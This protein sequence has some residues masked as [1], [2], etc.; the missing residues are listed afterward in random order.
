MRSRKNI[1]LSVRG[2]SKSYTIAH[3]QEK[4]STLAETL[5]QRARHPFRRA[6]RETFWALKDVS[7]EINKGEVVGIIGRNGAGKSTLL[8]ILSRI[9][10]PTG[11][12]IDLYGRVG[13]LLEVGT[14]FH[15]ELT[16]RENIFLNGAVLGMTR[17][18]IRRQFDTIVAFAEIERFLDTPVKRYSSGMYVRLAFSIAAHLQPDILIL[19]EVLAV[20]DHVFQEKCFN[21]MQEV[22]RNG[23][24]LLFVS[25]NLASVARLCTKGIYLAAGSIE[26]A[27]P[28]QEVLDAYLANNVVVDGMANFSEPENLAE[29]V[30]YLSK[31]ELVNDKSKVTGDVDVRY[32]YK[33]VLHYQVIK[34]VKDVEISLKI[35]DSEMRAVITSSLSEDNS[36]LL[37]E[38]APGSYTCE[39]EFPALFIVPGTYSVDVAIHQPGQCILDYRSNLMQ[40]NIA[41]TGTPYTRYGDYRSIGAVIHRLAW[42]HQRIG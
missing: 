38:I 26:A 41:D 9:T 17:N 4:Q 40:F 37:T 13:S 5:L 1:A 25:H 10:E 21:K 22:A 15:P 3:E 11:G 35:R 19:D 12:K 32:K 28:I 34:P 8:K 27:G 7:F 30:T 36:G 14:G 24:T 39:V 42:K 6:G 33:F 20:G 31:V 29:A 23:H 18:E 16:G 2:L